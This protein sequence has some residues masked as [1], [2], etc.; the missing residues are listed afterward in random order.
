MANIPTNAPEV[1][2]L[3]SSPARDEREEL[4]FEL[5]KAESKLRLL[6]HNQF[7][8]RYW[9]R[10]L[11]FLVG[12]LVLFGMGIILMVVFCGAFASNAKFS[13]VDLSFSIVIAPVASITAI[14]IALFVSAFRRFEDKDMEMIGNGA[15]GALNMLR[16][17]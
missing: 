10:W 9:L 3:N 15:S 7:S 5:L 8:Q 1:A 6:L 16:N 17:G 13:L 4:E 11:S 2:G 14:T 12:V